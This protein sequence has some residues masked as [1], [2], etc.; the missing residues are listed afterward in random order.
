MALDEGKAEPVVDPVL[1]DPCG[2]SFES[3]GL[4]FIGHSKSSN[5]VWA[6]YQVA[7]HNLRTSLLVELPFQPYHD[8]GYNLDVSLERTQALFSVVSQSEGEVLTVRNP[9]SH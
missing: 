6:L 7:L 2:W 4:Y 9:G 8:G 3:D 5:D 1:A